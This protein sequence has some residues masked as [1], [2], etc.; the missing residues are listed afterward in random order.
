MEKPIN[1]IELKIHPK[2]PGYCFFIKL[3]SI[4]Q[5]KK[6]KND[7]IV[8]LGIWLIKICLLKIILGISG[9]Y[10][11]QNNKVTIKMYEFLVIFQIQTIQQSTP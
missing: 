7:L 5:I 1:R 4:K 6:S 11:M 10:V 3:L 9:K 2:I 8:F